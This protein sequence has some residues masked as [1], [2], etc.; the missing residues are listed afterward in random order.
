MIDYA[1]LF[2]PKQIAVIGA[3]TNPE[4]LGGVVMNNS[5]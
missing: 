2:Q 1:R 5:G 4:K 3:S